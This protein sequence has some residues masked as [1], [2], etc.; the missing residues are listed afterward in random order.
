MLNILLP[1]FLSPPLSC[2]TSSSSF[3]LFPLPFWFFSHFSSFFLSPSSFFPSLSPFLP[4]SP[5]SLSLPPAHT[6]QLEE[7]GSQQVR[8]YPRTHRD[9][10][11]K[12]W[13]R[14]RR[15]RGHNCFQ[16]TTKTTNNSDR[17]P[18]TCSSNKIPP[19]KSE[20]PPTDQCKS[21][22]NITRYYYTYNF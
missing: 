3:L 20:A 13:R 8:A 22:G 2:S 6:G 18:T 11:H 1:S 4:P 19:A 7:A 9:K 16:E 21:E 14:R 12:Q 5:P 15:S 17:L 10:Q